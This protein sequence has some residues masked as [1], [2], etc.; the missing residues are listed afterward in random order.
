MSSELTLVD[1]ASR[2]V[3]RPDER[4][5]ARPFE[6]L[7]ARKGLRD[8][9]WLA[10]MTF[11]GLFASVGIHR[12][13][14]L[15]AHAY[16]A[17]WQHAFYTLPSGA[18]DA[19]LYSPA[20]AQTLWPMTLLPWPLFLALWMAVLLGATVWLIQPLGRWAVPVFLACVPAIITGNVYPL[21][22]VVVVKGMRHPAAWA[23]PVLTKVTPG[24][25]LV[26]FVVRREW[27]HVAVALGATAAVV[28][29]SVAL[30]PA[31]W[32]HWISFL[33]R[34]HRAVHSV[35]R[36]NSGLPAPSLVARFPIALAVAAYSAKKNRPWLL[37]VG[38]L[39]ADPMFNWFA[40]LLL[41]AIPRLRRQEEGATAHA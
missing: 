24:V 37:P 15:D 3:P 32:P 36:S 5:H 18:P 22:A 17:M 2:D 39:L 34:Q 11:A 20:F 7:D 26:W 40:L 14:T 6:G 10:A 21:F 12:W 28:A 30:M 27:R 1:P 33:A 19:Y 23:L 9:L 38:I 13:N 8:G 16:W 4:D 31:E 29:V 35:G 25:G 41:T